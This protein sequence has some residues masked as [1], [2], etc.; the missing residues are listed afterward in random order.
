MSLAGG[1]I[2]VRGVR[3]EHRVRPPLD[4]GKPARSL[5][6]QGVEGSQIPEAGGPSI[7]RGHLNRSN[8]DRS[9]EDR[10]LEMSKKQCN[11][12]PDFSICKIPTNL[13]RQIKM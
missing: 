2:E 13:N 7:S 1:L 12:N 8:Q 10:V 3:S 11:R 4:R 5:K 9:F 6:V